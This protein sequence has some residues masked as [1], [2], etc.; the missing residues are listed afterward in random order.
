MKSEELY[1]PGRRGHNSLFMLDD[2][3]GELT[4]C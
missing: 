4:P 3:I 1:D 2:I